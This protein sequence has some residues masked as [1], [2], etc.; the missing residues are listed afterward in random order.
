MEYF[1][2]LGISMKES[3]ICVMDRDGKV[4]LKT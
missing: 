3:H 4:V 2:G 1:A